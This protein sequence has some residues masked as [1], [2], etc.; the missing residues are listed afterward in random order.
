M[1]RFSEKTVSTSD[2]P[3]YRRHRGRRLM[4]WNGVLWALGNGL[5]SSTLVVYLALDLGVPGLGLGIGMIL[6]APQAVGLLRLWAP[7]AIGRV[8]SRETFCIAMYVASGLV[9]SAL[10]WLAAPG[11]LP[12]PEASLVALVGLWC[13]YHLLEYLG[14]VAIWSWQA[15]LVPLRIRGRF[16]GRREAWMVAGRVTSMLAAGIFSWSWRELKPGAAAWIGYAVP[17]AVGAGFMLAAVV[18]LVQV[19]R[20]APAAP[21]VAFAWRRLLAPLA[22][23]RFVR[24][25]VFGCWF[26]FFNGVTQSAQNIYPYR[27]LGIGLFTMLSLRTMMRLGQWTISPAVGRLADRQGN[28]PIIFVSLL[29]VATGPL[30]LL[31]A[32]RAEPW[33][34]VGAWGAWIAYAGLN[35]CLPNLMLY[36]SPR[37]GDTPYIAAYFAVTGLFYAGS[38]LLGGW[39]LDRF[40]E[41]VWYMP[42]HGGKLDFYQ[43]SFLFGWVFR[44]LGVVPLLLVVEGRRERAKAA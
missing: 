21:R 24:L 9:L 3:L 4:Y 40:Q 2:L 30:F 20:V 31:F 7:A 27:A 19:P 15:D 16:L 14:T 23:G 29:I 5:A 43:A 18:P 33:W 17:A 39:L 1:K 26:S 37:N 28:R 34:I 22:D 6:A 42:L 36:L 41:A 35:V 25:L 12:S 8:A 44:S 32:S 38:T 10:P 11:I 13:L